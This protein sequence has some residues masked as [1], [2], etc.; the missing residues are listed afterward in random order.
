MISLEDIVEFYKLRHRGFS[1]LYIALVLTTI[2]LFSISVLLDVAKFFLAVPLLQIGVIILAATLV[3]GL[4]DKLRLEK[5][6][7][8]PFLILVE[9]IRVTSYAILPILMIFITVLFYLGAPSAYYFENLRSAVS[10]LVAFIIISVLSK[11]FVFQI[12]IL[13]SP[14]ESN[15]IVKYSLYAGAIIIGLISV[16]SYVLSDIIL[17]SNL[18]EWYMY[19][20]Y[21][22]FLE[23]I[24]LY[25]SAEVALNYRAS[26]YVLMF[27]SY[28]V[29]VFFSLTGGAEILRLNYM[30]Y[31]VVFPK[32]VAGVFLLSINAQLMDSRIKLFF[33][34]KKENKGRVEAG[35][36]E[37]LS[38]LESIRR[39]INLSKKTI[40]KQDNA[41]R[42]L[43][44]MIEK[45][46]SSSSGAIEELRKELRSIKPSQVISEISATFSK[47]LAEEIVKLC[48]SINGFSMNDLAGFLLGPR[49]MSINSKRAMDLENIS[50]IPL[51]IIVSIF[52]LNQEG[53]TKEYTIYQK[54]LADI[55]VSHHPHF[56]TKWSRRTAQN[57][58][59]STVLKYIRSN[60]ESEIVFSIKGRGSI[61]LSKN[62]K[63]QPIYQAIRDFVSQ[64][65]TENLPII[66]ISLPKIR[67]LTIKE[68]KISEKDIKRLF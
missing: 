46:S 15:R 61:E 43:S 62:N 29:I 59:N 22:F 41:I 47:K 38:M 51:F 8:H 18:T 67:E 52:F 57:F 19:L 45:I 35:I 53:L 26:V 63:M 7:S 12:H 32:I 31:G 27:L 28:F 48:S 66:L 20:V 5:G 68:L 34:E 54:D 40:E 24:F 17:P 9:S 21:M 14:F 10:I 55:L 23:L 6:K 39:D 36:E 58:I 60:R 42:A 33:P 3:V 11:I 13:V 25:L 37:V 1:K 2:N 50:P 30:M 56:R 16:F 64:I 49:S 65:G 4:L 44:Y